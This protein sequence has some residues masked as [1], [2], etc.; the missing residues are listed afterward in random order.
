MAPTKN[1]VYTYY[2]GY[3]SEAAIENAACAEFIVVPSTGLHLRTVHPIPAV[4]L[5]VLSVQER[6]AVRSHIKK[7]LD[8]GRYGDAELIEAARKSLSTL[9]AIEGD[10]SLAET[11]TT[12]TST[13]AM[14]E[15]MRQ[16]L[17]KTLGVAD[18]TIGMNSMDVGSPGQNARRTTPNQDCNL[19]IRSTPRNAR[20]TAPNQ[21]HNIQY[22]LDRIE[23]QSTTLSTAISS[24]TYETGH[25]FQSSDG[26]P[27][28]DPQSQRVIRPRETSPPTQA[29]R[30]IIEP[31][32]VAQHVELLDSYLS[33]V[34]TQ[35]GASDDRAKRLTLTGLLRTAQAAVTRLQ[36]SSRVTSVSL[37]DARSKVEEAVSVAFAEEESSSPNNEPVQS[38]GSLSGDTVCG[39]GHM[40]N[41]ADQILGIESSLADMAAHIVSTIKNDWYR[42]DLLKRIEEARACVDD[43]RAGRPR[44][45]VLNPVI[46]HESGSRVL[47]QIKVMEGDIKQVLVEA[48][49]TDE[50]AAQTAIEN[51]QLQQ[52]AEARKQDEARRQA[53][54]QRQREAEDAARHAAQAQADTEARTQQADA[55]NAETVARQRQEQAARE[56]QDWDEYFRWRYPHRF[57]PQYF[58]GQYPDRRRRH[59]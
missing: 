17:L 23:E 33:Q 40:S 48:M 27:E 51:E 14:I 34:A 19:D 50:I 3:R 26:S 7:Q 43:L 29:E 56:R 53:E 18:L 38:D 4:Y 13:T 36:A 39:L 44:E 31:R 9:E 6:G 30:S 11:S 15:D 41:T 5:E 59:R 55:R 20:S 37:D 16:D 1:I 49:N 25:L 22:W 8:R 42:A 57:Y 52:Q 46:V 10:L 58:Y 45:N 35:L 24:A 54:T 12:N 47:D 28:H 21:D 2:G 32:H